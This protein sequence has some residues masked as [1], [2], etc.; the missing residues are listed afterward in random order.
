MF[1]SPRLIYRA[2]NETD[3]DLFYE[4]YSDEEVMKYAY[5]DKLT[6]QEDAKDA[7]KNILLDQSA[8]DIGIQYVACIKEENVPIGIVDYEVALKHPQGGIFEIGYFIKPGYWGQGFGTEMG[9]ALINY[10]FTNYSIHK[11]TASC[12]SSNSQS[13]SIMIKL[14][15]TKEGVSRRVRYKDGRWDDELKYSLLKEEWLLHQKEL[16]KKFVSKEEN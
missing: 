12:N 5:L 16:P 11:V 9:K 14:G 3:F 6:S 13:E 7:F 4:L 8:H 15:M 2:L 10:L 1:E